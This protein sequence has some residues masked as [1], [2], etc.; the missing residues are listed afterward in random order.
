MSTGKT[1][2]SAAG[3]TPRQ[4]FLT[5]MS[6]AQ[7]PTGPFLALLIAAL[8][9]VLGQ[10]A[11][12]P[13]L[14]VGGN[15]DVLGVLPQFLM[16]VGFIGTLLL[17]IAWV[18]WKERRPVRSLGFESSHAGRRILLGICV[19]VAMLLVVVLVSTAS[20]SAT[21]GGFDAVA[22]PAVLLLLVGFAVQASTEEILTR[23]YLLQA[24]TARFGV[25]VAMIVQTV[26]FT[27]MHALNGGMTFAPILNLALVAVFL[28]LWAIWEG[29]LWGVCAF[30][31]VWNWMQGNVIGAEVSNIRVEA[32]LFGYTPAPGSSDLITGGG[33]GLE[34]SLV[35][36]GMLIIGIAVLAV[37]LRRARRA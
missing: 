24:W 31:T 13:A 36:S 29:G 21:L 26:F 14:L 1:T 3:Q 34:G 30:H 27:A 6:R 28:G 18:V 9:M 8:A 15:A 7:R 23:G 11:G 17:L 35:L 20:G 33:F 22:L 2:E 12:V 32:S 4:R 16:T 5:S 25:V 19:A 37:A 10:I